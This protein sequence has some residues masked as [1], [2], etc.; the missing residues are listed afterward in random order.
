MVS[1]IIVGPSG[2]K[3][4]IHSGEIHKDKSTLSRFVR[5]TLTKRVHWGHITIKLINT[6]LSQRPRRCDEVEGDG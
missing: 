3:N 1:A 2:E 5:T 6:T 4:K